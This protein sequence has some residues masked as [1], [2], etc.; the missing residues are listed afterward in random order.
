MPKPAM[1]R[2]ALETAI[3]EGG[4]ALAD[5]INQN[6]VLKKGNRRG[7]QRLYDNPGSNVR[8]GRNVCRTRARRQNHGQRKADFSGFDT[9]DITLCYCTEFIISRENTKA[10][11]L[12]CYFL[13][14]LGDSVVVIDDEEIIKVHV[15]TNR[16]GDVLTKH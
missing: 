6:P 12:L 15:H 13:G 7:R 1:I 16:P 14:T 5:T 3:E 2:A 4:K 9:G 10:S 8:S 11:Q